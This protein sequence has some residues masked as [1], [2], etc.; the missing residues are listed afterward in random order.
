MG[1]MLNGRIPN[2]IDTTARPGVPPR[3]LAVGM[4]VDYTNP[5]GETRPALVTK[6]IGAWPQ[7]EIP[8][9]L[10][11]ANLT[12]MPLLNIAYVAPDKISVDGYGR[13][14]VRETDVPHASTRRYVGPCWEFGWERASDTAASASV[15]STP[16]PSSA[17]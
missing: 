15:G 8:G 14:V 11:G 1:G 3:P 12:P 4:V 7:Q 16:S 2:L 17:P 6:I 10:P 5:V 9:N 13:Q